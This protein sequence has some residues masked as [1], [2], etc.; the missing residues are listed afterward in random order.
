MQYQCVQCNELFAW[1]SSDKPR[2]PKCLRQHGLRPIEAAKISPPARRWLAPTLGV[3]VIAAAVGGYAFYRQ[4][5]KHPAGHPPLAPIDLDALREDVRALAGVDAGDLTTLLHADAKVEAFAEQASKGAAS[6]AA[7]AKAIVAALQA[8]ERK[9]AFVLWPRSEARATPPLTAAGVAAAIDK[10]GARHPLYPLEVSALAVAALRSVDVPAML[11]E[12]YRYPNERA[13][14]DPTG[15]LGYYG[16]FV[17][18]SSGG[19]V[20]DAYGG[21]PTAAISGNYGVLTDVEAVGAALTERAVY[22]LEGV[23]DPKGGLADADIAVKLWPRSP[24]TRGARAAALLATGGIEAGTRELD[25]AAQLRNDAPRHNNLAVLGLVS[26]DANAAAKEISIALSEFPDYALAHVTL[27]SVHLMRGERDEGLVEIEQ[28]ERLEPSLALLPQLWAEFY[29]S[30]NE[31]DRAIPKA[32]EAV[33]HKP[34][35][36]QAHLLL[37]RIYRAA[38]R[39]DDMRAQA[40][41]ILEAATP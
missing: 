2:C 14:L 10:D 26:G 13:P 12:V 30:D 32:L 35:D 28:A 15:R 39:Y 6:N 18:S 1:D 19:E 24:A 25:D 23:V 34:K 36:P 37:A 4:A 27:A 20:L 22:R 16:V 17:P 9:Q 33:Q 5:H 21:R 40:R 7:K 31:F 29:A 11:A 8:R 3:F 41:E 38:G